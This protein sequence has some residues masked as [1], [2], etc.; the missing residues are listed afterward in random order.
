MEKIAPE[1]RQL[2]AKCLVA[3]TYLTMGRAHAKANSPAVYIK[4][5]FGQA[6]SQ[7]N[8]CLRIDPHNRQIRELI[9][10]CELGRQRYDAE[11]QQAVC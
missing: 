5:A 11:V 9:Q 4:K 3:A 1:R 6:R 8:D 2:H 10:K 7:L